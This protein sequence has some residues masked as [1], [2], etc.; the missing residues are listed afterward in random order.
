MMFWPL[1]PYCAAGAV[2]AWLRQLNIRTIFDLERRWAARLLRKRPLTVFGGSTLARDLAGAGR[3]LG[4]Q[5]ASGSSEI[6]RPERDRTVP[7][8]GRER[9][10]YYERGKQEERSHVFAGIQRR[11][12]V[13]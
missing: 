3:Q 10:P 2:T 8:S 5:G 9:S 6:P 7:V 1:N 12:I 13:V 4:R 11:D